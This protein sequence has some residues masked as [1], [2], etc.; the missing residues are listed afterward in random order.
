LGEGIENQ[1]HPTMW[2]YQKQ[3]KTAKPSTPSTGG[4]KSGK[5]KKVPSNREGREPKGQVENHKTGKV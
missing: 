2:G 5:K 3:E 1:T 4:Q